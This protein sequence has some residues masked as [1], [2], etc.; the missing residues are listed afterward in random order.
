MPVML[1]NARTELENR[2]GLPPRVVHSPDWPDCSK[3]MFLTTQPPLRF[4]G[5]KAHCLASFNPVL[6]NLDR[7]LSRTPGGAFGTKRGPPAVSTPLTACALVH[8]SDPL[9]S[10]FVSNNLAA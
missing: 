4:H 9:Q 8:L 6:V 10:R 2:V 1:V 5:S 3:H 7:E